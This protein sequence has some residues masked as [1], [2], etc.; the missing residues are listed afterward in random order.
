[1][2]RNELSLEQER[3][4]IPL[5][6]HGKTNDELATKSSN[7]ETLCVTKACELSVD[8][9]G[10][11]SNDETLCVTKA[12]ELSV[13]LAG[14][15]SNDETPHRSQKDRHPEQFTNNIVGL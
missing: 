12:C 15:S 6:L 4:D 7:D 10:K 11:S 14:K 9:A 1:M 2:K 8:L 3:P 13:D 5:P